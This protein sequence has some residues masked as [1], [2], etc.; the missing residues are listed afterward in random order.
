ME[1]VHA[2]LDSGAP[3]EAL[4]CRRRTPLMLAAAEGHTAIVA[5]LARQVRGP[6]KEG[7]G[8]RDGAGFIC[9]GT[10]EALLHLNAWSTKECGQVSEGT[11]LS[12][13]QA[14]EGPAALSLRHS[15][16]PRL[17]QAQ[18]ALEVTDATGNTA[19]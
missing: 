17:K 10:A 6:I 18:G 19:M 3:V 15:A 5:V 9:S 12:M 11:G 1:A 8:S 4:D 16:C 7:S 2:L 13:H 14:L